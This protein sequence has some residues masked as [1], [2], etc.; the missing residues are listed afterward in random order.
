MTTTRLLRQVNALRCLRLLQAGQS[1][2]RADMARALGITRAT[3]GH[4]VAELTAAGLVLETPEPEPE[5]QP[6]PTP[7]R[8]GRP[9]VALRLNPGGASFIGIEIDTR[10][11]S[12][13]LLDLNMQVIERLVEQTGPN[14]HDSVAMQARLIAVA[15]SLAARTDPARIS[16]LGVAVPGLVGRQGQVVNAPLLGWRNFPL[17]H[18]LTAA[19]PIDWTIEVCNDAFAFASA[20]QAASPTAAA[21]LLMVLLAEGVGSAHLANGKLIGG[22]NGFAG[23]LGHMIIA[24][25]GRAGKLEHMAGAAGFPAAMHPGRPVA[26]GVAALIAAAD[27][28]QTTA[29]LD[30]WAEALAT[31]L[32]N[33]A[34]L[35]D[36]ARIVL[37]GPL[38][39]LYPSVAGKVEGHLA[40]L[41][42]QGHTRP[43]ITL[44]RFG[45]EGA[46]IGAAASLR[47][48]L[49]ALPDLQ[50]PTRLELVRPEQARPEQARPEL[51]RTDLCPPDTAPTETVHP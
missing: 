28:P 14:F 31:G 36:P 49:F 44:A 6:E 5:T 23:E 32:A 20:E 38:S 12:A 4:A 51:A 50:D 42:L 1:L 29:A 45:A 2:S 34:H 26:E 35:L 33:A 24:V 40:A 46:A 25:R 30:L 21:S 7:A 37:G 22:A 19:L 41:M 17:Q 11:I 43:T 48:R 15:K 9:G 13:V 16:G 18:G 39:A 8:I 10:A 27:D 3:I 47:E